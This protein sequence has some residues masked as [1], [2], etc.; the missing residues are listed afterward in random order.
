M[1]NL[2]DN[3]NK[4]ELLNLH[5]KPINHEMLE[6]RKVNTKKNKLKEFKKKLFR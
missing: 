6:K 4:I 1:R 5:G 2:T 3:T